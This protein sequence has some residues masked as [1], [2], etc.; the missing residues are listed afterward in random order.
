MKEVVGQ[1]V[2]PYIFF[3][4]FIGP[5]FGLMETLGV[6]FPGPSSFSC[7]YKEHHFVTLHQFDDTGDKWINSTT[8]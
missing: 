7:L 6:F 4:P 8:D 5:I 3:A 2:R 1:S